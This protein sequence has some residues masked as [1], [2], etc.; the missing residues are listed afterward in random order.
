MTERFG[1]RYQSG[2][3]DLDQYVMAA[4][5]LPNG[6]QAWLWKYEHDLNPGTLV[7]VDAGSNVEEA[8]A[9]VADAFG[10]EREEFLWLAPAKSQ[11]PVSSFG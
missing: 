1:L 3:D 8:Q 10:L 11:D 7:Y 9:V 2:I 4:V 5:E 6:E